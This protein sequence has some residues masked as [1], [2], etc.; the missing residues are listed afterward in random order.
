MN[1]TFQMKNFSTSYLYNAKVSKSATDNPASIA[2]KEIKNFI[3]NSHRIDRDNSMAFGGVLEDIK[4]QQSSAVLTSVLLDPRVQLCIAPAPLPRAF[5][6][7]DAKDSKNGNKP[8][9]FIDLTGRVEFKNGYYV[10][11]RGMIDDICALLFSAL[12]YLLY[13]N[14]QP[15]LTN[16]SN[17]TYA[18]TESFTAMFA[19]IMDFLRISGFS[20]NKSKISYCIALYFLTYVMNYNLEDN[21]T[22]QI[23]AKVA[24]LNNREVGVYDLYLSDIDFTNINTFVT[25]LA[26]TFN[27]KEFDL[28]SFI[29]KWMYLYGTGTEYATELY[30]SFLSLICISYTGSY[31][32]HWKKI[33]DCCGSSNISKIAT[34]V[35]K[36]G[37]DTLNT[38]IFIDQADID[39]NTVHS[40]NTQELAEAMK[41]KNNIDQ[42]NFFVKVTEFKSVDTA[43][44]SAKSIV[45]D[46]KKALLTDKLNVFAE[47]SIGSGIEAI[48]NSCLDLLEGKSSIEDPSYAIGSLTEV[49]KVFKNQL[50]NNQRYTVESTVNRDIDHM[51]NLIK[52]AEAPKEVNKVIAQSI[53][54]LRTMQQYI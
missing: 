50:N 2:N 49:A 34:S 33:E 21:Y 46:C 51:S 1:N 52:E 6:V 8:T 26:A 19:Y 17:L 32:S 43:R 48:Y 39:L 22:K 45:E 18:A 44:D 29:N 20:Q 28:P 36:A 23:A 54:E 7:F 37:I 47:K 10:I 30:T 14:A 3:I 4:R 16:N 38:K 11:R 41:L 24:G 5:W 27:M 15:K 25:T 42:S 40:K 13:R 31:I 12:V 35:L 9:V 53:M